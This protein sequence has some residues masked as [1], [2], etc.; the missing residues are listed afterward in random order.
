[1][2]VVEDYVY[3]ARWQ[4][5]NL[6]KPSANPTAQISFRKRI[7]GNKLIFP[8]VFHDFTQLRFQLLHPAPPPSV[9]YWEASGESVGTAWV[10]ETACCAS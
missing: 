3:H 4:H 2:E 1:M 9:K 10:D 5:D 7:V 8:K 6:S